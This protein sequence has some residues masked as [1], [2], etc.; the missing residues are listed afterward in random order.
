V[1]REK[2]VE[3]EC[4]LPVVTHPPEVCDRP[5]VTHFHRILK[6][7]RVLGNLTRGARRVSRRRQD[8]HA[9]TFSPPG[10]RHAVAAEAAVARNLVWSRSLD[11]LDNLPPL[12]GIE[13]RTRLNGDDLLAENVSSIRQEGP[14]RG[15]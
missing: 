10:T 15:R 4:E 6:D 5:E 8:L 11:L 12:S 9:G 7:E 14:A 13:R 3:K 2:N 1:P